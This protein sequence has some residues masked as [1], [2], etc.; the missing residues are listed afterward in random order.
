MRA[1]SQ[2]VQEDM[3]KICLTLYEFMKNILHRAETQHDMLHWLGM[4]MYLNRGRG[5]V[6]IEFLLIQLTPG[7]LFMY[8]NKDCEKVS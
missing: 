7:N 3:T 8:L 4:C 2:M 5:K 1:I 6:K